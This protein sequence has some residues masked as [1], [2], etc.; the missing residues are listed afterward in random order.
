[1]SRED[2]AAMTAAFLERG[3][4]IEVGRPK[5]K[6]LHLSGKTWRELA[7]LPRAERLVL[8][9]EKGALPTGGDDE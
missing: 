6:N 4:S 7:K 5:T 3:G 8:L 2:L 1:M 9:A